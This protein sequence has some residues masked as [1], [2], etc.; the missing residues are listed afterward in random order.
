MGRPEEIVMVVVCLVGLVLGV[1]KAR[2]IGRRVATSKIVDPD[3]SVREPTASERTA[4]A[5][6]LAREKGKYFWW[7]VIPVIV[8]IAVMIVLR[9]VGVLPIG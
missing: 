9:I 3:G 1:R 4:I 2:Q 5:N 6:K 7:M 8:F